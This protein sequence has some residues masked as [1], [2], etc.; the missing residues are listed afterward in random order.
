ME[1]KVL[2]SALV[3]EPEG[4]TSYEETITA[5][6][7]DK[8]IMAYMQRN[9]IL[10]DKSNYPFCIKFKNLRPGTKYQIYAYNPIR[11]YEIVLG[12][13]QVD[14]NGKLATPVLP[15]LQDWV[16]ILKQ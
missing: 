2:R 3:E 4:K 16:L 5:E 11:D 8:L 7:P 1:S 13:D 9:I 6:I 12:E 10:T 14:E 15:V